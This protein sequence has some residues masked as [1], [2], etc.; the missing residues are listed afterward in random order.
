[1][2]IES[3]IKTG[4]SAPVIISHEERKYFVKLRAG[5]SS[6]YSLISE[7]MGNR[8]GKQMGI[9]TQQPLW[10]EMD[11]GIKTDKLYIE[12]KELVHKSLG[13]NIGFDYKDDAV[14]VRKEDL[15]QLEE[16][17]LKEI[18]LFDLAMINIDRTPSNLNLMKSG[19]VLYSIDYESSLLVQ[20]IMN[21]KKLLSHPGILQC[22]RNNPLYQE[23]D[24]DTVD[25][26]VGKLEE[27]AINEILQEVPES[28][29][30]DQQ[31]DQLSRGIIERQK[32]G[33]MLKETLN[34]LK[35]LE[36]ETEEYKRAR[37]RENQAEFKRKFAM[38]TAMN[39]KEKASQHTKK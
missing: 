36:S 1:M 37:N 11:D 12:V 26:F 8:M 20:E 14:E 2:K 6:K 7:W 22:L 35:E 3:Y 27:F 39:T 4:N 34:K 15:V 24:E 18:F 9:P 38:N 28:V 29:I 30:T 17:E 23:I 5:M 13:W 16:E 10:I 21:G 31:Y 25:A 19:S 32:K 33:W